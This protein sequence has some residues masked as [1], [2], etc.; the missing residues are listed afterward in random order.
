MIPIATIVEGHGEVEALPWGQVSAGRVG[1]DRAPDA[2]D[3]VRSP[4]AWMPENYAPTVDQAR[5][6]ARI[7]VS[8]ARRRSPSFDKLVRVMAELLG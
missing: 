1:M 7:D 2:P 8:E 4:K 5:F 3:E 6:A